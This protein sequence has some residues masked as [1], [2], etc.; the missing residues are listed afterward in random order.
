MTRLDV[1]YRDRKNGMINY[2]HYRSLAAELRR[3]SRSRLLVA[4]WRRLAA[5][6]FKLPQKR[7]MRLQAS[8]KSSV[9]VA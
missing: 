6:F 5:Y 3:E 7:W 8:S 9:L 4:A 1:E 2:D